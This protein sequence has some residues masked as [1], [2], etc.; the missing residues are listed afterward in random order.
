MNP[1]PTIPSKVLNLCCYEVNLV[2]AIELS[3]AIHTARMG[4]KLASLDS[5]TSAATAVKTLVGDLRHVS[6]R[7]K[8]VPNLGGLVECTRFSNKPSPAIGH[9]L[10]GLVF[11]RSQLTS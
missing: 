10:L 5:L 8:R 1:P 7:L 3:V 2:V 9:W 6:C 4:P 11:P